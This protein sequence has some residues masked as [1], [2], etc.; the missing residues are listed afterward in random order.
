MNLRPF[1]RDISVPLALTVLGVL[2]LA[3]CNEEYQFSH[4]NIQGTITDATT[5]DKIKLCNVV[6]SNPAGSIVDRQTTDDSGQYRTKDLEDGRY[7]VDFEKEGYYTGASRTVQVTA[8][9]HTICDVT[10]SRI[11]AKITAD[12]EEL[13]FGGNES[14]TT[15][16]FK[17][18]NPYHDALDW[19][20]EYKCDWIVSISPVNDNLAYGKTATI[21]V[22]IDREKL[23][24]GEN[25]TNLVVKSLN[26]QGSVNVAV[27]AVGAYKEAPVLNV[28]KVTDIDKTVATLI[29]EVVKPGV[30]AY[31]R[32]GFTC[33]LTSKDDNAP[34]LSSE[35]ND[36]ATFSYSVSGLTPG[37]KYY[38]RAFAVNSYAGK[39]WSANEVT[40]T[41]IES[42][43]QVR[44]DPATGLD[45]VNGTCTING[46][47]VQ[48]GNPAY[49]EKGFCVSSSGDPTIDS[50][51][52]PV[53][54]TGSGAFSY[55]MTNLDKNKTYRFRAYAIQN[56]RVLYGDVNSFETT[57]ED[58]SVSTSAASNVTPSSATL[59]GSVLKVG[60]P[61]FSEVGFCYS[62]T[63]SP[64][65]NSSKVS[66][67]FSGT[68]DYS[69]D[70]KNLAYNTTYRY[71]AYAIQNGKPVYGSEVSFNTGYAETVIETDS[72]VK[73]INYDSAKLS[74]LLKNKGYPECTEVGICYGTS[75]APTIY[76]DK[77][78]GVVGTY[79]QTLA[80]SGLKESTTYYFRAYA[81][82]DG[83]AVY[84]SVFSFQTATRPSVSTL[85]VSNLKNPYG[86][87]NMWQVQLNGRVDSVGSPTITGRGFKISTNGDPE[88]RGTS[89]SASGSTAGAFS[90]SET[91]LKSNMTYYVRAYVKNS[92]GYVYGELVTFT[93]GD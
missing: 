8:E 74:F 37:K 34:E 81:I 41:T 15:L 82:Q 78:K 86:M 27:K 49:S 65:I 16:S 84:G 58:T 29:G 10:L 89:I 18:V 21:V 30:P 93:T 66:V 88:T 62:S 6:V 76:H 35:V 2:F 85:P 7:T 20:V 55:L 17:I 44:T 14:L 5:G 22:R 1:F 48:A 72:S 23:Q 87:M 46:Y 33:S 32:R 73:D 31:T 54:G 19:I 68:G 12:V 13:D 70:I 61:A 50:A 60:S 39:V 28:T 47:V 79:R 75:S 25:K 45:L 56:G 69:A 3:S 42:Y 71:K 59:N 77:V 52:H 38:V 26:G 40:F 36:K 91:G 11:P 4:G 90:V 53:S 57:L 92:L 64:T 43:P 51:K 80:V 67:N 63:S 24:G 83:K 9:E